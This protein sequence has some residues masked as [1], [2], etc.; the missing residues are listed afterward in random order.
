MECENVGCKLIVG[1]KEIVGVIVGIDEGVE[2]G[3]KVGLH[4]G[5]TVGL[6]G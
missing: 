2:V 3:E 5:S 4:V 6:V 1:R